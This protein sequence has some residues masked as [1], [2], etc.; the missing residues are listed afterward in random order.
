M[1]SWMKS[2]TL[3]LGVVALPAAAETFDIS[4]GEEAVRAGLTGSLSRAFSGATGEYDVG[5]VFRSESGGD[6]FVPHVGVLLTGD[7]GARDVNVDAGLGLRAVY[8]D[9]ENEDGGALALSGKISARMPGIERLSLN[10]YGHYAPGALS[11]GDIDD[12]RELGLDLS[13]EVIKSASIYVGYREIV[14]DVDP[15]GEIEADDGLH[16]GLRLTF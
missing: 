6:A 15:A 2:L 13:Y 12:Y 1:K 7:T 8:I 11:F 5:A 14:A 3:A 4:V 10:L 9:G 16:A